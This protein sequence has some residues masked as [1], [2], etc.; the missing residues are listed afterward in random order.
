[1]FPIVLCIYLLCQKFPVWLNSWQIFSAEITFAFTQTLSFEG[2]V[3]KIPSFSKKA[4]L[5]LLNDTFP[6]IPQP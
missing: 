2:V 4:F 5:W 6:Y 1:M 3:I